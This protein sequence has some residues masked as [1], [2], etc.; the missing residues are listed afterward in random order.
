MAISTMNCQMVKWRSS[1]KWISWTAL[2]VWAAHDSLLYLLESLKIAHSKWRESIFCP[3]AHPHGQCD[4]AITR[5]N[6]VHGH[7]VSISLFFV[8]R[9]KQRVFQFHFQFHCL[10]QEG[11]FIALLRY[12][13]KNEI[14]NVYVRAT[15]NLLLQPCFHFSVFHFSDIASCCDVTTMFKRNCSVLSSAIG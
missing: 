7:V 2:V 12:L 5:T 6:G 15:N 1:T 11:S 3:D 10:T 14:R 4:L 13:T 9:A 8:V